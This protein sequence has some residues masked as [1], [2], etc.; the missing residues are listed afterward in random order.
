[1]E[2]EEKLQ[3]LVFV[4]VFVEKSGATFGAKV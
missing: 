3:W 4:F 2:A 1:M